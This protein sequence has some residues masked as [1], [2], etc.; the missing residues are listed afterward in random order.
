[1]LNDA[2]K[3]V[4]LVLIHNGT[5]VTKRYVTLCVTRRYVTKGTALQNGTSLK[6]IYNKTVHCYKPHTQYAKKR[7]S[8]IIV[9]YL[10]VHLHL[11]CSTPASSCFIYEE[12]YTFGRGMPSR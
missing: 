7:C 10:K 9:K 1:M 6:D 5:F 12:L 11:Y 2:K 8:I 4:K 3:G